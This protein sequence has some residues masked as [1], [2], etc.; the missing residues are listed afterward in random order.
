MTAAQTTR[1][2][3]ATSRRRNGNPQLVRG[4][5]MRGKGR[6]GMLLSAPAIALVV[7][8][9]A[10]P[11]AQAVYYS[12]TRWDGLTSEWIGVDGYVQVLGDPVFWRVLL[13]NATLLITI[14]V[15]LL[16]GLVVA[17]LVHEQVWGWRFFRSLYFLPTAISWVVIGMVSSRFFA[18]KG[19]L[20]DILGQLGLGGL[21]SDLLASEQGALLVIGVTFIW[22]TLGTSMIIFLTGLSTLDTSVHEAARVDGAG[23]FRTFISITLPQLKRYILFAST[24]TLISAFTGLFSLIFVMTGGGPGYGTTTLE[25][26]VYQ[27][28]FTKGEFGTG[29]LL[30]LLLFL[31]MAIVGVVQLRLLRSDD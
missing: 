31:I 12:F 20:N 3:A 18:Q 27:T 8:L 5:L 2:V 26:F 28:A 13:N 1:L 11:I 25:F 6:S 4:K 29:A 30:G 9:L 16:F 7:L 23:A 17:I 19:L 22:S 15:S 24:I 10:I 21:S 14:P